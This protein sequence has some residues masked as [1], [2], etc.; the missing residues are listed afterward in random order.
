MRCYAM[1]IGDNTRAV[2]SDCVRYGNDVQET[3][4]AHRSLEEKRIG[5]GFYAEDVSFCKCG[6]KV[7]IDEDNTMSMYMGV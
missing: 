1:S 6:L 3:D 2:C 5:D 4:I 7:K